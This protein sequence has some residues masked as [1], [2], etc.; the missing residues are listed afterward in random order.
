LKYS[1]W[2]D[3]ENTLRENVCCSA[4]SFCLAK[5][6]CRRLDVPH[7]VIDVSREFQKEVIDYFIKELKAGR[8][9]NPCIICNRYLKFKKL[10][11]VARE[12]KIEYIATGHYARIKTCLEPRQKKNSKI[13][14]YELVRSHDKQKD[15]TYSLCLLPQ[16]WLRR[17]I[18]PLADYPKKEVFGAAK[19]HGFDFYLK[20]KESQDFC[21][22][23][24]KCLN[25]FLEKEIGQ[26]AG[27]IR[28]VSGNVLGQHRGLHFYTVGQR[29]G[30]FLPK[31]PYFVAHKDVKNNVLAVSKN[32]KDLYGRGA[33]LSPYNLTSGER[34]KGKVDVMVKVRSSAS[35]A[36][37]ILK[38]LP[39][40]KL[41]LIFKKPQK[42]ITPGQFAVFYRG[43]ICLG[44]GRIIKNI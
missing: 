1:I 19:N 38:L 22:V 36:R 25:C 23:A 24:N 2:R 10:F 7:R 5:E 34:L 43:N 15:Q 39:G 4:E 13:K 37:A 20:R 33:V 14:K 8:T 9:P 17:V 6:V 18:F 28:D 11:E 30:L 31:G 35:P 44:G 3:K 40:N 21:F 12:E 32:E 29:K 27:L 41:E 16:K 26:R 42:A